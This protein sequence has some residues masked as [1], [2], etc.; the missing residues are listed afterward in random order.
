MAANS[1][2][3]V[4]DPE[5]LDLEELEALALTLT[6]ILTQIL[7]P[8]ENIRNLGVLFDSNLTFEYHIR[9]INSDYYH[10]TN[11]TKCILFSHKTRQ[12]H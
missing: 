12:R 4:I 2:V 11:I 1:V 10:L 9:H 8:S 7:N 3:L 6:L 5:Q